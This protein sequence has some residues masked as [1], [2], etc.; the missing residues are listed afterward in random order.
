MRVWMRWIPHSKGE[1]STGSSALAGIKITHERYSTCCF[2]TFLKS[3]LETSLCSNHLVWDYNNSSGVWASCAWQICKQLGGTIDDS[4]L[5]HGMV[6]EKGAK[7]SAGGPTTIENAKVGIHG[8][9]DP[10]SLLLHGSILVSLFP[11][12]SLIGATKPVPGCCAF[13][14][15]PCFVVVRVFCPFLS[16]L[17]SLRM[18]TRTLSG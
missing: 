16:R 15:C 9:L 1:G 4:E 2:Q 10:F 5:V 3:N 17:T 12:W 14:M 7:K 6:F 8:V 13:S 11:P 18:W